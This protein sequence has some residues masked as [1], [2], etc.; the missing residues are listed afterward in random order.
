MILAEQITDRT[1][2]LSKFGW[3]NLKTLAG[4]IKSITEPNDADQQELTK[5]W[6]DVKQFYEQY[7]SSDRVFVVIQAMLPQGQEL[8]DLENLV[9]ETFTIVPNRKYGIQNF[10]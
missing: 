2:I 6:G 1:H 5:L 10:A 3:G 7:Y 4:K 8:Q 9:R